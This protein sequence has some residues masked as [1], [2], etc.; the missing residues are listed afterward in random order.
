MCRT[1]CVPI[2]IADLDL[3]REVK[4]GDG[5]AFSELVRRHQKALYRLAVRF[6]KDHDMAEDVVQE[7]FVKAYEKIQSFEE[8]A[9]FKSWVFR[10]AINTCKN[11]IR[12][13]AGQ[14]KTN[15]EDVDLAVESSIHEDY[16][17]KQVFGL[18]RDEVD[19]LPDRQRAALTLR[20]FDEM[21]FQEIAEVMGCPYDTAKANYRHAVLKLRDVLTKNGLVLDAL[22]KTKKEEIIV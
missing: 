15:I 7:S 3:V 1:V 17:F 21:S 5:R 12:G 22:V 9:S 6:T 14:N 18:V 8:R 19:K 2:M 20:V 11:K 16:E 4:G 10:I 13:G